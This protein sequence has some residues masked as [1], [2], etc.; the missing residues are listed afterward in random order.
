VATLR[1]GKSGVLI[2]AGAIDFSPLQIVLTSSRAHLVSYP[3]STVV[4]GRGIKWP[5]GD[6]DHSPPSTIEVKNERISTSAPTICLH[7]V[8][9]D[10]FTCSM[11]QSPS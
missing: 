11:E 5:G 9:T 8:N 10:N 1:A 2:T 3:I 4:L 6:A 7:G